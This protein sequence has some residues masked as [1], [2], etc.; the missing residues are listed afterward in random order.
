MILAKDR[1]EGL[2]Y[3]WD[4]ATEF[5]QYS[6]ENIGYIRQEEL[7]KFP[8]TQNELSRLRQELEDLQSVMDLARREYEGYRASLLDHTLSEKRQIQEEEYDRGAHLLRMISAFREREKELR[9]QEYL[10]DSEVTRIEKLMSTSNEMANRVR[11]AMRVM[12]ADLDEVETGVKSD[13]QA[14]L[15]A[16]RIAERESITLARDLHDGP[17]QKLASAVLLVELAE[18]MILKDE[19]EKALDEF[20][21]IKKQI[22]ESLWDTRSFLLRL[23]PKGLEYGLD[24]ALK[25]FIDQ[26]RLVTDCRISLTSRGDLSGISMASRSN[27]YKIIDQAVMNAIRK[28]EAGN[29][30]IRLSAGRRSLSVKIADDGKG[31]DLK[32]AIEK[33]KERGSFGLM[34]MEERT[35]MAGGKIQIDTAP[36]KGTL[37]TLEIPITEDSLS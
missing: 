32:D 31:F 9:E 18:R 13:A 5:L 14:L 11:L 12:N 3:I 37:I 34:N 23:N 25:R 26:L 30:Q 2:E 21:E 28:G 4:K 16:Y 10:L 24:M 7:D 29:I 36:G 8:E 20:V 6:M 17:A 22:R 19:K 15:N 35:R 27:I 1:S 33:A